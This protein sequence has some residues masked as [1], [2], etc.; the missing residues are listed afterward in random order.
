MYQLKLSMLLCGSCILFSLN[1]A[2]ALPTEAYTADFESGVP[3]EFSTGTTSISQIG[4]EALNQG[5]STYLGQFTLSGT[6]TLTVTGLP[7]HTQLEL[8]LDTY[9]FNTWDG[10]ATSVGPDYFS[11]AGDVTFA[12]TFTNHR[13]EG[14]S[15]PVLAD[16]FLTQSGSALSSFGDSSSTMA[17][18]RLGPSNSGSSFVV[19]HT[20]STF[21]VTF[22]GPTSQSDEQWGIDNIRVSI[23]GAEIEAVP[24]PMLNRWGLL[25]FCGLVILIGLRRKLF[26]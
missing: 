26:Q 14:D 24:V 3:A 5:L 23:D 22:G 10:D 21:T 9:F 17:F 20:S 18:F 25:V 1:T 7:P 11:L 19:P 6:T 12:E 8:E 16:V 4:A 15:Y 13:G 2:S